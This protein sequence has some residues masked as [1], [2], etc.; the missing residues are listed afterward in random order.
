[1]QSCLEQYGISSDTLSEFAKNTNACI[2]GSAALHSYINNVLNTPPSWTPNDIDFWVPIPD[3]N[4]SKSVLSNDSYDHYLDTGVVLPKT[5]VKT[6]ELRAYCKEFFQK[7]GF[8]ETNIANNNPDIRAGL[9]NYSA[10]VE[11]T[12]YMVQVLY[13]NKDGLKVQVIL[14]TNISIINLIHGF[15]LSIC[16]VA[17]NLVE[18]SFVIASDA[19]YDIEHNIMRVRNNTVN[20]SNIYQR[21]AKYALRGFRI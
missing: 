2:A 9:K 20:R 15:D 7:N 21:V 14:T 6:D 17:W 3:L 13:F 19:I 16:S 1:M 18:K 11:N 4:K 12:T 10:H 5:S 8:I